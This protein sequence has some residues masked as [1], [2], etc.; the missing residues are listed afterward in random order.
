MVTPA[1]LVMEFRGF[2]VIRLMSSWYDPGVGWGL[3]GGWPDDPPESLVPDWAPFMVPTNH[4]PTGATH[5]CIAEA[6]GWPLL[7][8][9]GGFMVTR[10]Q[11]NLG[12]LQTYSAVVLDPVQATQL[13]GWQRA[14]LLPLSPL[15]F[16]FLGDT[17][18]YGAVAAIL[19]VIL[20]LPWR[21][22]RY[23]RRRAGACEKCAHLL[24]HL[25]TCP[26]C[27]WANT[28]LRPSAVASSDS[29]VPVRPPAL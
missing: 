26:E 25:S 5:V 27:G 18:C 13:N 11:G 15:P 16:G 7:A 4:V 22:R 3:G 8:L 24:A 6:R 23:L 21:V 9:S 14:N 2:G 28:P 20:R 19:W 17:L 12:S 1:G 10:H 29:V